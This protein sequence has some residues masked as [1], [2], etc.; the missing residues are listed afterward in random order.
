MTWWVYE[1]VGC[2]PGGATFDICG[3]LSLIVS[4]RIPPREQLL[5]TAGA[6]AGYCRLL[7]CTGGSGSTS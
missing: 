3:T 5:T 2:V 6:G 1:A 4:T 7:P